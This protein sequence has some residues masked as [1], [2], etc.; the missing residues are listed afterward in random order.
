M[1]KLSDLKN[2]VDLFE[3]FVDP[4]KVEEQK[5]QA[6]KASKSKRNVTLRNEHDYQIYADEIANIISENGNPALMTEFFKELLEAVYENFSSSEYDVRQK[7]LN[8]GYR[9]KVHCSLQFKTEG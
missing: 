8:E 5:R 3:D 4:E 7:N 2:T 9:K 1:S 6:E